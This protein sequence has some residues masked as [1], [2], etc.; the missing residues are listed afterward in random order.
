MLLNE[1]LLPWKF[2][3]YA[4]ASVGC[5]NEFFVEQKGANYLC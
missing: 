4:A 3:A 2:S 5:V 1:P